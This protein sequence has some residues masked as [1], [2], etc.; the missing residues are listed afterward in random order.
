MSDK[1]KGHSSS[2]CLPRAQFHS[3]DT[4]KIIDDEPLANNFIVPPARGKPGPP[5][6]QI[7][8]LVL[9]TAQD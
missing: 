7:R 9:P 4:H 1:L 3:S 8:S 6:L 2:P 5:T